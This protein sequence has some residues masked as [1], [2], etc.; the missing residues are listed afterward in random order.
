M[1]VVNLWA[2]PGAGKSTTA[3]GLFYLL[4][5]SDQNVE[6]V[7]EYAKDMTW[8]GRHNI[9][10][11]Q[12]YITAK[13]N[14]RLARLMDHDISLVVTDSPLLLGI[15][16]ALPGYLS[17]KYEPMLMELW[18]QYENINFL[19]TRTKP[20]NPVGRNQDEAGALEIDRALVDFLKSRNLPYEEIPG[21][22]DAPA[23]IYQRL[24]NENII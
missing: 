6:L 2:G 19:I 21:D 9:L 15:H 4:K 13:Q 1:R 22:I 3:S 18:N 11:D 7:T 10:N 16:Y 20:Y 5:A 12:L 17:G 24:K 8:E 14:R 23:K